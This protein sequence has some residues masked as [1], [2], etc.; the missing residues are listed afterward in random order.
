MPTNNSIVR[1]E[2]QQ[3][4]T[5]FDKDSR[6]LTC[7]LNPTS[8]PTLSVELLQSIRQVQ[9]S[10]AE[11]Y[12]SGGNDFPQFIVWDSVFESIFCLGV[13]LEYLLPLAKSNQQS[14][15]S[16]YFDLCADVFYLNY[17]NLEIPISTISCL[18]HRAY[19]AGFDFI[20]SSDIILAT[21]SAKC[22]YPA[23]K[24]GFLD[25]S[26]IGWL[27]RRFQQQEVLTLL[28]K[29]EVLTQKEMQTTSAFQLL[30]EN[31]KLEDRI[32]AIIKS[33]GN[34]MSSMQLMHSLNKKGYDLTRES[35]LPY[36]RM[37]LDN[38]LNIPF[39][40]Y[41]ELQ[42]IIRIQQYL[43]KRSSRKLLV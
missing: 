38:L 33:A 27:Q 16:D 42:D 34:T 23:L 29:G 4:I 12:F 2:Y 30:A 5:Y 10:V 22:G 8:T 37:W 20:A 7:Y 15:L 13:D 41:H 11:S 19:G 32:S 24:K 25:S 43:Y 21:P 14:D 3:L 40:R 17:V 26:S 9:D 36:K 39:N 18:R 28:C 6:V 1:T 35:I 31:E